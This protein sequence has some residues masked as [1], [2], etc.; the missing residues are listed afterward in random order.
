MA[1]LAVREA[2]MDDYARIYWQIRDA[3]LDDVNH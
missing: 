3:A 1:L 2:M